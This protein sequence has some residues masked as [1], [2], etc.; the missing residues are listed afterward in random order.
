[1]APARSICGRMVGSASNVR[2][3]SCRQASKF[4]T[5]IRQKNAES[6]KKFL[7]GNILGEPG[8]A[9]KAVTA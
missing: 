1:M 6:A 4:M 8:C 3:V 5:W 7:P 9:G 2:T